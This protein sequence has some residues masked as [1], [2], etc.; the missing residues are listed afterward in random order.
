[1]RAGV[2][3]YIGTLAGIGV[4]IPRSLIELILAPENL[5]GA[6]VKVLKVIGL[7]RANLSTQILLSCRCALKVIDGRRKTSV[8]GNDVPRPARA[9]TSPGVVAL[10]GQK[11][12]MTAA[13]CSIATHPCIAKAVVVF[14]CFGATTH[15][16]SPIW[17]IRK[18]PNPSDARSF[19]AAA[20]EL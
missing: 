17:P 9:P 3:T 18:G 12:F 4:R 15:A 20:F 13:I 8:R 2:K 5:F 10:L 11:E 7:V 6:E 1:M 16:N 14:P 19:E